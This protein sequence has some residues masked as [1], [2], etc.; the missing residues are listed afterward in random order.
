MNKSGFSAAFVLMAVIVVLAG[1]IIALCG[2]T[3]IEP[4][5]VGVPVRFGQ[6]QSESLSEGFHWRNFF[7][8][9]IEVVNVRTQIEQLEAAASTK[10]LQDVTATVALNFSVD[11]HEAGNLFK[12]VGQSYFDTVVQ[13]VVME[14]FKAESAKYT[15]EELITKRSEMSSSLIAS[16]TAQLEKRGLIVEGFS[17]I[18]FQF[19]QGFNEAVEKKIIAEQEALQAKNELEKTKV[20]AQKAEEQA[21]G[22]AMAKKAMAEGEAEAI[23]LKAIAE[24]EAITAVSNAIQNNQS[25]LIHEAITAWDGKLPTHFLGSGALPVLNID[26][27]IGSDKAKE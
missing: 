15:A 21:R 23:K 8:T 26:S 19:S 5:T 13:P 11:R 10:D 12:T 16:L 7:T 24:A 27:N 20:E 1:G 18:Q 4:G 25:V 9:Y 14:V 22:E 3:T 17:I 2:M 6:V